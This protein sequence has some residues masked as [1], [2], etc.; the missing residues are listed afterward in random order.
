[1]DLDVYSR[2]FRIV[3]CD[4]FT[5]DFYANEGINIGQPEGYPDDPFAQTRAMINMK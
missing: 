5:R 4:S 3:D 1:M 2:V